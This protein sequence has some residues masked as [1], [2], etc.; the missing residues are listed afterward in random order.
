MWNLLTSWYLIF[1]SIWEQYISATLIAH[2]ASL[3]NFFCMKHK[4]HL[5]SNEMEIS[6]SQNEKRW[7]VWAACEIVYPCNISVMLT[8]LLIVMARIDERSWQGKVIFHVTLYPLPSR[9]SSLSFFC[10]P[11]FFCQLCKCKALPSLVFPPSFLLHPSP[12]FSSLLLLLLASP[13]ISVI[14]SPLL[15]HRSSLSLSPRSPS[16]SSFLF[17]LGVKCVAH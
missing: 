10:L 8:L 13:S 5:Q 14:I 11:L 6:E 1:K 16:L 9:T 17:F 12:T 2:Y 7:K 3:W 4:F 15:L